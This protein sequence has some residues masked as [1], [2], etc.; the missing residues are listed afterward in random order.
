M[1]LVIRIARPIAGARRAAAAATIATC[2]ALAPAH[3]QAPATPAAPPPSP[4]WVQR[5]NANAAVLMNVMAKFGP[6]Q[7]GFFGLSGYDEQIFDL[8]PG[9][10]ERAK[11]ATVQAIADLEQRRADREGSRGA[12]GPRDPDPA[13]AGAEIEGQR[14]AEQ[15]RPA[16]L[17][18]TGTVFQGLR[19]L[20]DDQVPAGAPRQGAGAAAPLRRPREGLRRR[21]PSSPRTASAS[22]WRTSAC[23]GRSRTRSRRTSRNSATLRRRHRQAVREV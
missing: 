14:A 4:A 22:G 9:L 21:S 20:L 19:A 17:R 2:L 11:A 10:T 12:P 8:K 7:A 6:E 16:V 18:L 13:R 23:S 15:V 5:S 1:S 3:A